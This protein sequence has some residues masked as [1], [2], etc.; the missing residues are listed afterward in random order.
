MQINESG[1]YEWNVK[2]PGNITSLKATGSVSSNGTAKVYVEKDGKRYLVFDSTKPLFDVN[3]NVLPE[4]KKIFQGDEILI[5]ITL[6]NLRGFG[7]GNVD[8]KYLIKDSKGNVIAAEAESIFVET[9]AK[10]IRKLVVPA[11]IKTGTYAAFVE[12]SSKDALVGTGSDTF[13]VKSK[14]ESKPQLKYYVIGISAVVLI[15][16]LI[17][18]GIYLFKKIRKKQKIVELIRMVIPNRIGK[19]EKE[20]ESLEVAYK[21]KFIS[22]ESY[23]KEKK[24]VEDLLKALK[25]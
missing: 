19:L 16:I 22:E 12:G 6:F 21:S 8:V 17:S 3:I 7:A 18:L 20:L 4:Y 5:Q 9:Q 13:E 1:T 10:F 15:I 11:D 24:R 2:N 25:K 14:Y 23:K